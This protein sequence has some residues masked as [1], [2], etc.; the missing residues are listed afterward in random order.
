MNVFCNG[1]ARNFYLETG[2]TCPIPLFPFRTSSLPSLSFPFLPLFDPPKS[3]YLSFFPFSPALHLS[4]YLASEVRLKNFSK[5]IWG[6]A[7][8]SSSGVQSWAPAKIKC[9]AL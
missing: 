2:F 3:Q 7:V 1:I 4:P 5:G 6:S 9:D 8:S